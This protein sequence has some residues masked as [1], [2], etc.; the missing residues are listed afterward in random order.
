MLKDIHVLIPR[1]PMRLIVDGIAERFTT[2]RLWEVPDRE[3][4][5]REYGPHVRGIGAVMHERV[6]G[7][8]MDRLPKL[9]IVANF[10]DQF[11]DLEGEPEGWVPMPRLDTP[12]EEAAFYKSQKFKPPVIA[13]SP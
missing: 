6:D 8:F 4:W 3:A 1:P 2:H 10:G 13:T 11:S 12:Q 5:F 7:A 9:E